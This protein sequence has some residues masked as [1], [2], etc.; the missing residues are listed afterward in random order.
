MTKI[1]CHV[2]IA[3]G[4][5][6]APE[7]ASAFG[8]EVMQIFTR[9]PQGGKA[10]ELTPEIVQEFKLKI[11]CPAKPQRS[12]EN[13]KIE[14]CYIHTPYYI[15]FASSNPRIKFGSASVVRDELERGT[16]LGAKYVM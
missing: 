10:P 8:C 13:Y 7:R 2:S 4:I 1:G 6:K 9:S 14:N 16:L 5:D 11:A 15:N 12:G 3:G